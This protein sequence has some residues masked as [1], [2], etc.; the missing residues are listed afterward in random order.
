MPP[1]CC[2][3]GKMP[4]EAL[5]RIVYSHVGR[6]NPRL[7][8]GPGIGRD[9]AAV[10]YDPILILTIHP[11]TGTSSRIGEHSVYINANDIATA[12]AKPVWYLWTILLPPGSNEKVL[13][14]SMN[15]IAR[16]SKRLGISVARG[17]TE[18][19]GGVDG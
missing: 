19:T 13:S 1:R 8:V 14:D 6:R 5:V 4:A 10:R 7:L 15:V 9:I 12:G 16:A 18:E 2:G 17:N 11:I 3:V